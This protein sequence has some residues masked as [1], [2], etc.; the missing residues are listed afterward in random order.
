MKLPKLLVLGSAL[1]GDRDGGGVVKD[2]VLRRYP[3]DRYVCFSLEPLDPGLKGRE[4]PE[5]LR[6]VPYQTGPLVPRFKARGARFY[7][8]LLRFIGF[9]II[10]NWR[11]RQIVS[12]ARRYGVT[13]VWAELQLD[14][15]VIAE[16]VAKK[17]GVPLVCT[18]WD[19]PEGWFSDGGY[20]RVSRMLLRSRFVSALRAARNVST[21]GESMQQAYSREYGISSVILRHGFERGISDSNSERPRDR[22]IVGF[23]GNAY[24]RNT[25][26]AFLS[27]IADL[28]HSNELA[29]IALRVFGTQFPYSHPGINIELRGW[30]PVE[31]TLRGISDSDFCYLPYWFEAN[32]RRHVELSFPNKFETYLASGRPVFFHGPEYAGIAKTIKEFE[33]GICIHTV[34]KDEIISGLKRIIKDQALKQHLCMKA[35]EAFEKEFNAARMLESFANLIGADAEFFRRQIC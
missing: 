15:V 30:Q 1:P 26:N 2:E 19:D 32:K 13:L 22:I 10:A 29:Q 17:L 11:I 27:A 7:M 34:A 16:K 20:D 3:K 24:A 35:H 8:P 21:A 18:V 28:N 33:V 25:W 31:Q 23:V 4:L 5:S 12:F 14:A 9:H 6:N